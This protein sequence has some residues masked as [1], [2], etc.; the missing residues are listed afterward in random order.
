MNRI[1]LY[2]T[3]GRM[4][5]EEEEKEEQPKVIRSDDVQQ[6]NGKIFFEKRAYISGEWWMINCKRCSNQNVVAGC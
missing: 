5:D 2:T 4:D 6:K 1:N 3:T